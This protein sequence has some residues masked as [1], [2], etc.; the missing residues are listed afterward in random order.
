MVAAVAIHRPL[1]YEEYAALPEDGRRYE[2]INGELVVAA[3]PNAKHLVASKRY[4]DE[5]NGFVEA[6]DL[7][8]VFYAP[9]ELKYSEYDAVQPD[10]FFVARERLWIV[11]P[12]YMSEAPDLVSETLSP[13]NWRYDIVTKAAIYARLGVREYW[14]IDPENESIL[15]QVLRDGKY[16]EF[17]SKDGFAR[18]EILPGF[19]VDPKLLFAWPDWMRS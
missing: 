7:G 11:Q 15:V 16:L 6:R 14:I 17:T 9:Y 10:L 3:A 5:L 12:D 13:S 8:M 18:S 19:A 1:T 2:L 4:Y